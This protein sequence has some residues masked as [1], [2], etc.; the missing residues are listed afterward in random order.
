M[1]IRSSLSAS[2]PRRATSDDDE[3]MM[4]PPPSL[5]GSLTGP[6]ESLKAVH[7]LSPDCMGV[8]SIFLPPTSHHHR[9]LYRTPLSPY[10]YLSISRSPRCKNNHNSLACSLLISWR[11][12]CLCVF[13]CFV[14]CYLT[15]SSINNISDNEYE[16]QATL[17][18][19]NFGIKGKIIFRY[20]KL[21]IIK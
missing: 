11:V 2:W 18:L 12:K 1:N 21:T 8:L 9:S 6:R 16:D 7:A 13:F 20:S 19:N 4:N 14:N 3:W 5:R 10:R 15:K 17:N